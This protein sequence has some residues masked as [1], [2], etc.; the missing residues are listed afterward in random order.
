MNIGNVGAG[1]FAVRVEDPN[2]APN[3]DRIAELTLSGLG[4]GGFSLVTLE[5]PYAISGS[6]SVDG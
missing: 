6:A 3:P 5:L 4:P 2:R 1:A